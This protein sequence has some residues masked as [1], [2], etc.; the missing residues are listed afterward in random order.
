MWNNRLKKDD[1]NLRLHTFKLQWHFRI[2]LTKQGEILGHTL[3]ASFSN[4][5]CSAFCNIKKISKP[6]LHQHART[7]IDVDK[8]YQHKIKA[9]V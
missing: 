4:F 8:V 1:L 9:K 2:I 3:R 7:F 5:S 6:P